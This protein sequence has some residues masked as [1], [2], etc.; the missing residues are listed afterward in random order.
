MPRISAE[1]PGCARSYPARESLIGRRVRCRICGLGFVLTPSPTADQPAAESPAPAPL[2]AAP[3]PDRIGR[4]AIEELLGSGTFGSVYRALD[5]TLDRKVSLKVTRREF[6]QDAKSVGRFL[7]MAR[8]AARLTH[9]NIAPIYECGEVDGACY[10]ASAHVAGRPLP[11]AVAVGPLEPRRAARIVA[12]LAEALDHG[13][14]QGIVHRDVKPGNV[15]LDLDDRPHLLDFGL[16]RFA[17]A[18]E[19]L[20]H[21]GTA[22]GSP[23][24]LAPEQAGLGRGEPGPAG[25]QYSLGVILYE[26]LCGRVPFPGPLEAAIPQILQAPPSSLR[27]AQPEI[28]PEL[29]A[30]CLKVLAKRPEDRYPSCHDLADD[31]GRWLIG[32]PIMASPPTVPIA[33]IAQPPLAR[34]RT[35]HLA[36]SSRWAAILPAACILLALIVVLMRDGRHQAPSESATVAEPP[37]LA[38]AEVPAPLQQPVPPPSTIPEPPPSPAPTATPLPSSPSP[39][40]KPATDPPVPDAPRQG[41]PIELASLPP[42][43][44][45]VPRFGDLKLDRGLFLLRWEDK[46]DGAVQRLTRPRKTLEA[47][48]IRRRRDEDEWSK[49]PELRSELNARTAELDLILRDYRQYMAQV[50]VKAAAIAERMLGDPFGTLDDNL[51]YNW[52][53]YTSEEARIQ[54]FNTYLFKRL[55]ALFPGW[56]ANAATMQGHMMDLF[57]IKA[58]LARLTPESIE[59]SRQ[60]SDLFIDSKRKVLTQ[61]A[62][63]ARGLVDQVQASY[64]ILARDPEVKDKL[65]E[66]NRIRKASA[67]LGPSDHFRRNVRILEETEALL[68]SL[69]KGAVPPPSQGDATPAGSSP[70]DPAPARR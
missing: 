29:E 3:T 36:Q 31:L 64:T 38:A 70:K 41:D 10:V 60:D 57:R 5:P 63:T 50:E 16:A 13:H 49:A 18:G 11:E 25:D 22:L 26:L 12:E 33:T 51:G 20:T 8:L 32:R 61:L 62:R 43:P 23:A 21:L 39:P 28:P 17:G 35:G 40:R 53:G 15:L 45:N 1:C 30:I 37:S 19:K 7:G 14:R 44:V 68:V 47:E 66:A 67:R 24:Y 2:E 6:Q 4:F 52:A 27:L 58:R 55:N 48:L 54:A 59:K 56:A 9:P 34:R 69:R 42:G 46:V 65:A